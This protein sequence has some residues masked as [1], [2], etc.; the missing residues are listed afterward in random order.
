[1]GFVLP[2]IY[3][4]IVTAQDNQDLHVNIIESRI[5]E[6]IG[7]LDNRKIRISENTK[8]LPLSKI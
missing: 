7:T 3:T 1:M 6:V 5:I 4:F 8:K 2:E